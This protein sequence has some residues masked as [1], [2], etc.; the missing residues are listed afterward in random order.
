M[1]AV[2]RRNMK[3]MMKVMMQSIMKK[4]MTGT[5]NQSQE[6]HAGNERDGIDEVDGSIS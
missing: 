2:Q 3:A 5:D 1:K 4:A 6:G